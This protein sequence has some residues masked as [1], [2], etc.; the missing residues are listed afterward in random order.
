MPGG[1]WLFRQLSG[2]VAWLRQHSFEWLV[3]LRYLRLDRP[4]TAPLHLITGALAVALG[5]VLGLSWLADHTHV[6]P[7]QNLRVDHAGLIRG[8][9]LGLTVGLVLIGAF[10]A[11]IK[12]LTIFTTISTY[13]LF[14]GSAALVIA[15]SVMSGFENDL[16]GKILG[17]HAHIVVTRPDDQPF[18]EYGPA[19]AK[20][21][22]IPGVVGVTPF[23]TNEVMIASSSNL[24]GVVLKGID[25]ETVE[26]VTDL[27]KNTDVGGL[28]YLVAPEKLKTI[29]GPP[30]L[31]DEPAEPAGRGD[32]L[33]PT[34]P[35]APDDPGR[36]LRDPE[37]PSPERR[38]LPGVII[39]REL[40]K[41]LRLYLGDDVNVVSPLGGIGPSGPIPKSKPFRVAGIFFSGMFEYDSKHV[42]MTIP[43][44]QKF[45]GQEGEVT[46]LELKIRDPEKTEPV[47]AAIKQALGPGYEVQDW[48]ELNRNLFSALKLE[49][50]AMFIVLCFIILVAAFS[51]IANG[52]MLVAQKGSEIAILKAMGASDRAIL[53]V[54][55]ILGLYMGLVG[56]IGGIGVGLLAC[57]GLSR[58]GL[59]LDPDVYY[60]TKLPVRMNP[61]EISLVFIAAIL[62]AVCATLYPAYVAARLKPVE[63]LREAH[64]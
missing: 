31:D 61:T 14:L 36:L 30:S 4:R 38:V 21:A 49:K 2:A 11:L 64:R 59:S 10:V 29:G 47:L 25:P 57:L 63:G 60:I 46:G 45:L 18:T 16:R 58:F 26:N 17:A 55:L 33:I 28:E 40:A 24:S 34:A 1:V 13:G 5:L 41:N 43:A 19:R 51:I 39:G 44:A 37:K 20:L 9:K 50:I 32:A 62:I 23:L 27:V 15:L 54:F 52:I 22:K 53:V 35:E 8:L 56:T 7:L 3:A 48:K 6:R 42:Y 12:R